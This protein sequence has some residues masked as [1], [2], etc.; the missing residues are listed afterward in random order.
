MDEFHLEKY[1]IKLTSHTKDSKED[2]LNELWIAIRSKTK[3]DFEENIVRLEWF[4]EDEVG[5]KRIARTKTISYRIEW[6]LSYIRDT[7]MV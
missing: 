3:Q 4:L 7:K 5:L 6:Q 2:K 1:L